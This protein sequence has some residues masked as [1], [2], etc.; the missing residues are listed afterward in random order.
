MNKIYS[1]ITT[2]VEGLQQGKTILYPTDTIYGIGGDATNETTVEKI[3][4]IKNR[5]K[6]KSLIVL[7]SD[8]AML[9]QYI[10]INNELE[11]LISSFD[12]PTTV[13]YSNPKNIAHNAI[14]ADQTIAIRI[15]KHEFCHALISAFGKP[16]ISTSANISG[17]KNPSTF[18]KINAEIKEK[19]DIIINEKF[20]TSTYKQ[21]SKL[22]KINP[23]F[24]IEYLR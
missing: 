22:I 2:I 13:I 1:D 17:E 4:E 3:F 20:D 24:S 12:V 18:N 9:K 10:T 5:P 23:D 15:P 14:N 6:S 11:N 19:V 21:A 7:V 16:I 8:I